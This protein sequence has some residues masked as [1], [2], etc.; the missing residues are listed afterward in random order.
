[1]TEQQ[2]EYSVAPRTPGQWL[3]RSLYWVGGCQVGIWLLTKAML[4]LKES[5]SMLPSSVLE[6]LAL[7]LWGS[8]Y[9]CVFLIWRNV[10]SGSAAVLLHDARR[11]TFSWT[12]LLMLAWRAVLALGL[13]F[14]LGIILLMSGALLVDMF[15]HEPV[16]DYF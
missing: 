9:G 3:L 6:L 13:V 16:G 15:F 11:G 7:L 14:H 10:L 4:G 12:R 8:C 2:I 1:M 5:L